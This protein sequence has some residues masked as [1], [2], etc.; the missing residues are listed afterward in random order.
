VLQL[1][2]RYRGIIVVGVLLSL[3]LVLLYAQTKK[4]GARGPV[5]GV[6]VEVSSWIERGLLWSVGGLL[7]GFE[8][9]VTSVR[10]YDEL[11]RLRRDDH[12]AS[13]L[14]GRILELEKE[15][16][17]LRSL[18]RAVEGID[19]PRPVGAR[20]VAR[21][22]SP[23]TKLFTLDVGS[24]DGV[25]RGDGVV[26]K[27]GVVGLVLAVGRRS[28]DVL[29]L[30]DS[31]SALDVVVQRTRARC[32]LRGDGS[33]GRYGAEVQDFDKLRDVQPGDTIVTS[34]LGA[35]FPA[36]VVVGYVTDAEAPA[37]SLYLKATVRPAAELDRVEHVAVLIDRPP[38]KAP[39]LGGR[40]DDDALAMP[41]DAGPGSI[42][43]PPPAPPLTAPAKPAPKPTPPTPKTPPTTAPA[44]AKPAAKPG[45][46]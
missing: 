31:S 20:V 41:P 22:G 28:C 21:T 18:A 33:N 19:G 42:L 44:T 17:E 16:E 30:S 45:A 34:G 24:A 11:V 29:L 23:L 39:R 9:Y 26:D 2:A 27:N 25:K 38:P 15:N 12:S 46:R 32:I 35:R 1:L 7:D 40:E 10:S 13:R 8:H 36:G 6:F 43:I 37:D 14:E 4:P 5:V 3:P